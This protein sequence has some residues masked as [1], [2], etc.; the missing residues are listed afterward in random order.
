MLSNS[1]LKLLLLLFLQLSPFFR[2][3][4][5][6]L[7]TAFG[8]FIRCTTSG[9][10]SGYHR[11]SASLIVPRMTEREHRHNGKDLATYGV[12]DSYVYAFKSVK[13]EPYVSDQLKV[14]NNETEPR[15]R[16]FFRSAL[17]QFPLDFSDSIDECMYDFLFPD[18][19]PD[20]GLSRGESQG[21]SSSDNPESSN[22]AIQFDPLWEQVKM[23]AQHALENEVMA[24]PQIY[25][26]I[27]S[28]PSLLSA[29]CSVIANE[30]ATEL[31]PATAIKTLLFSQLSMNNMDRDNKRG[32][33]TEKTKEEYCIQ[34]DIMASAA[35]S[36][37]IGNALSAVLFCKG[38]HALVCHR[39]AHRLWLSGR[40]AL[41]KYMQ[42]TVSRKYAVDIHPAARI[43]AAVFL[44]IGTG[45]VIGETA[46]VGDDVTIMQ[47][48]T[49]G[50]TGLC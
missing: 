44:G 1:A 15:I 23:E 43:G 48:V 3:S 36:T 27:L 45:I 4:A 41:A 35:R 42:S 30:I 18:E 37:S 32:A 2:C 31:M 19:G 38:L 16:S 39:V 47:G 26:G 24:G 10:E 33:S 11:E 14:W 8:R 25:Q 9:R 7:R 17:Q 6:V 12:E 13:E 28:Q 50:G 20:R 34:F 22:E 49:L 29:V 40:L 5:W 21:S 46:T